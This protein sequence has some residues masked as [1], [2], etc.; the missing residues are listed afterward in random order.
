MN[1][2]NMTQIN[3][4]SQPHTET[5]WSETWVRH[6]EAY[7]SAPPCCGYWIAS[8]FSRAL[9]VLE[10]A[11]GSCR[12]SH[13]LAL[14][15]F[16][17]TA[18]D[19]D[20]KTL[21]YLKKRYQNSPLHL[22]KE[23]AFRLSFDDKSVDLSFSNGFW[24][25]FNDDKI[26]SLIREQERVTKKF[27]ISLVHNIDNEPL[28]KRF[29]QESRVDKLYDIR[30]FNREDLRKIVDASGLKYKSITMNKFGGAMD[31]LLAK[32]IKGFNN[33]LQGLTKHVVPRMYKYQPWSVT[34][35]IACVIEL[36]GVL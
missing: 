32:S 35:R 26:I 24:I 6:I 33:P 15:G 7:L 12:D 27:I 30:F 22:L 25:Y 16:N 34:E 9:S 19:F 3:Q 36:R 11:G 2:L 17:V 8:H 31:K 10:I 18:S 4:E 5:F 1:S 21:D 14:Q 29:K 23:D 13:Y 20:Q 28:V